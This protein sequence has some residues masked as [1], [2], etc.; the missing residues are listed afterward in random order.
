MRKKNGD[1]LFDSTKYLDSI[2]DFIKTNKP[3]W[4]HKD[5]CDSPNLYFAIRPDGSFAPCCDQDLDEKIYVYDYSFPQ[6]YTSKEF[7][8]RVQKVTQKCSGCNFGSYPEMTLTVRHMPT[9]WERVKLELRGGKLMHKSLS[10]EEL[11]DLIDEIRRKYEG[12]D[13]RDRNKKRT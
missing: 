11:F 12:N 1:N 9:F 2:V 8:K 10:D 6:I 7:K 3:S 4:R 5:I 13:Y